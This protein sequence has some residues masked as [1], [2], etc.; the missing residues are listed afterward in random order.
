MPTQKKRINITVDDVIYRSL[1]RLSRK[2]QRTLSSVSLQL[3][4]KALEL[5]EDLYFS[6]EADKRLSKK[7]KRISHAKAW[8]K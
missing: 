1:D 5:E 7:D 2:E 4:E 6:R 8:D 3:I